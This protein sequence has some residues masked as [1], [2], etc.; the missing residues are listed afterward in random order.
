MLLLDR[1]SASAERQIRRE[2]GATSKQMV[3][4]FAVTGNVPAINEHQSRIEVLLKRIWN[5]S[6][7]ALASRVADA[8]QSKG[9]VLNRKNDD[10]RFE[11]F[12]SE[13]LQQFGG[14]KIVQISDTTQ[15]Q[16]IEQVEIGRREGLGQQEIAQKILGNVA[17]IARLRANVIARTETHT[18]GNFGSLKQAEDSG[19]NMMREWVA[20]SGARTRQTH[21]RADGQ[22][23]ALNQAFEIGGSSLMYPGDPSGPAKE[24]VNCRCA[25]AYVVDD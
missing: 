13:Y 19:L 12:V 18:S 6:I 8:A 21:S 22:I 7:V 2:I 9:R 5:A 11:L 1:L 3:D 10:D 4:V 16:I 17:G 20:S 15:T 24:T 25:V 23:V 14:L